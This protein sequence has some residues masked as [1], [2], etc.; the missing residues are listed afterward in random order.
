MDRNRKL[1]VKWL[2]MPFHVQMGVVKAS[3][4]LMH[5]DVHLSANDLFKNLVSRIGAKAVLKAIEDYQP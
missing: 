3:G 5:G 2:N 1:V 4:C